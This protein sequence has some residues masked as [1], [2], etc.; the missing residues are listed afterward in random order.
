MHLIEQFD[1]SFTLIIVLADNGCQGGNEPASGATTVSNLCEQLGC[2]WRPAVRAA[3]V[4]S[5]VV[6]SLGH[7]LHY[8][9]WTCT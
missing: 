8:H 3:R 9:V 4:L 6:H 7:L 5:C 1:M 2:F